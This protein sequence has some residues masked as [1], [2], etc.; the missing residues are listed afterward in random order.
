MKIYDKVEKLEKLEKRQL[1]YQEYQRYA[2]QLILGEIGRAGQGICDFFYILNLAILADFFFISAYKLAYSTA[3]SLVFFNFL[4]RCTGGF[5]LSFCG[6]LG[7]SRF[8][9]QIPNSNMFYYRRYIEH[10]VLM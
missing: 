4:N 1:K 2:R 9:K 10:N 8:P 5:K 3:T 7:I 6:S